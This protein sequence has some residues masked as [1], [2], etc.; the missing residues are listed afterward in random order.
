MAPKSKSPAAKP[1]TDS[2]TKAKSSPSPPAGAKGSKKAAVGSSAVA[3][4]S[5]PSGSSVPQA[6]SP[7]V[8]WTAESASLKIQSAGR[9]LLA[10]TTL[11]TQHKKHISAKMDAAAQD[12]LFAQS[13]FEKQRREKESALRKQEEN[14]VAAKIKLTDQ[15][16]IAAFDGNVDEMKQL[17]AKGFDIDW[18]DQQGNH[19]VGEAAVNGQCESLK[20]LLA[21][22]RCDPNVKGEYDR[23]PLWRAAFNS[24]SKAVLLLLEH[25]GD[26]RIRAQGQLP[27]ELGDKECK[28]AIASWDMAKTDA[29]VRKFESLKAERQ[30]KKQDVAQA[31]A[32]T[33]LGAMDTVKTKLDNARKGLLHKKQELERRI[34]EYDFVHDDPTKA[35]DLV[36]VALECVKT[37]EKDVAA[38][39]TEVLALQQEYFASKTACAIHASEQKLAGTNA[40]D[41]A[42]EEGQEFPF[43][44]L[45]DIVF[46]DSDGLWKSSGKWPFIQDVTGKS[47]TFLKYRNTIFIDTFSPA[48]MDPN[49]LR[50][51]LLGSLRFGKPLVLDLRD[52]PMLEQVQEHFDRVMPKLFDLV[53]SKD[54]RKKEIYSKLLR[55]DDGPEYEEG[56]F[57]SYLT[58]EASVVFVS[59]SL[60]IEADVASKFSLLRVEH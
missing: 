31:E 20:Y 42:E 26:P 17:V 55:S 3:K 19:A 49:A 18:K 25:G 23:T 28:A 27:E 14:K 56:K 29:L 35:R 46:D 8:T 48:Q 34:T 38:A 10:R 54:F 21:E 57:S 60:G 22:L 59:S 40:P 2:P 30:K 32:K 52:V 51:C 36:E 12:R 37:A 39:T 24:H 1:R 44:K 50:R 45:A 6:T 13:R 41:A 7:P 47:A 9:A 15:F 53:L 58:N 33:L 16:N 43:K 4:A 5:A 11:G